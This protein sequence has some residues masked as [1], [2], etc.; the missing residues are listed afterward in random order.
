M[1]DI[2]LH[3]DRTGTDE[4]VPSRYSLRVGEI[5]V[6][7][8]SDG[9]LPLP[10]ATLATNSDPA[11]LAAWLDDMRQPPDVFK[12]PLNVVLLRSGGRTVLVDAGIGAELPKDFPQAA[13]LLAKRLRAAGI[14]PASVTDVVITHMHVDHVGGLFADGLKGGLRPDVPIHLAAAEVE[15]WTSPDFSHNTFAG[16][17][18]VLRAAA[19]RFADEYRSQLR[20]FETEYEVAPGVL[21]SRTG[22]HTPGH[23][24]VRVA[25]SGDR[26]TFLGDSV[27]QDHFDRPDWYNA[28]DHDPEEAVRV[29][30]RLLREL[31]ATREPMVA[32]HVSFPYGRV[33]LAG[34]VFRWIP[35]MW[36][37]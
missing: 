4:R 28:F 27:F 17:P 6:L 31:A 18:H 12:W 9:V 24:I 16:M 33:A 8:I 13:G 1:N 23:S 15:F 21:I 2:A 36:E 32:A 10:A 14:D 11:E 30:T 35:T 19:R 3:A 37:Y 22:G 34:D 26:L 29:R 5:D 20:L 25:S 7:V